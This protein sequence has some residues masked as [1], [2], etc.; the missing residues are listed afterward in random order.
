MAVLF[1]V[2]ACGALT[3]AMRTGA[4]APLL[5]AARECRRCA[6][7]LPQDI[8][9]PKPG[10]EHELLA[11]KFEGTWDCVMKCTFLPGESKGVQTSKVGLGGF[12]V[13]GDFKGQ[14]GG[15]DFQGRSIRGYDTFKKKFTSVWCDSIG[16]G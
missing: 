1:L 7:P 3:T 14:F 6:D 12:F 10:P 11:K 15:G 16:T 13:V 4:I 5:I 8:P 2:L 9:A